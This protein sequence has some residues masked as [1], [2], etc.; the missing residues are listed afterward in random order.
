M[1]WLPEAP[2]SGVGRMYHGLLR[3]LPEQGVRVSGLV[4]GSPAVSANDDPVEAFA[5]PDTL[6]P[7][8]LWNLRSAVRAQLRARSPD[9]VA[10]HFALYTLPFLDLLGNTPLVVHFHGPWAQES[11]AEGASRLVTRLKEGVEQIAY[12]RAQRFIVLSEA[13]KSILV[14]EYSVPEDCVRVVPG[15]VNVE[16]FSSSL[17]PP[18]A[19]T[20]LG[21][22]SDRPI[23]LAVR[24][25]VRRVGLENLVDAMR[26][27][28]DHVPEALLLIAGKGPLADELRARIERHNLENHVQLLGFVPDEDLPLAYRAADVSVVPTRSL[29]GFGLVAVESLAAGTPPLVTPVG[30]L[31]EVVS[32]LSE[33][34]VMGG[35]S[36]GAIQDH[37]VAALN[38]SLS[39]PSAEACRTF[40]TD[41][42]D[43]PVIAKQVR[44]VYEPLL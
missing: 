22:P 5:S 40:A 39:L 35:S 6:L 34:L 29:E 20:R 3:H 12:R 27:V 19:R 10:S 1:E 23:L 43:W 30:G 9:V 13:F 44:S 11:K 32:G 15:G 14:D 18:D 2:G 4:T 17:T 37:L 24:R 16:R 28:R 7:R 31:P 21:W 41:N 33:N 38:G 36:T 25:L 26:H 42:Y 8:R